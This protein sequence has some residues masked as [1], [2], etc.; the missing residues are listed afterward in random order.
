MFRSILVPIDVAHPSSWVRAIPE[1]L[2]L[3][4]KG[5]ATVT[6][7]TVIRE[8]RA[9]FE[10]VHLTFQLEKMMADARQALAKVVVDHC[11]RRDVVQRVHIGSI[12][13][14]ILAA[15]EEVKA[16]LIV[17]ASHRPEMLDYLIGPNAAYV[18]QHAPCSVLVVRP[19]SQ[20]RA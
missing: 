2:E 4:E 12:S 13:A 5:Q 10:G 8:M 16:D 17:M 15:A 3:A 20:R 14:E 9:M 11:E 6:V 1:A 7:M 18:A 19:E